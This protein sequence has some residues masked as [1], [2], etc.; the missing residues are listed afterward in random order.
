M[1]KFNVEEE[2]SCKV[3]GTDKFIAKKGAMVAFKGN[4][5]FDKMLLGPD[6]GGGVMGSLL[7]MAKRKLTGE[8]IQLMTVEGSG[9]IYLAQNAYHVSV[10][11][12][13]PGDC[14][15]VE[16]ENLLAFPLELKYDVRFIGSGVLSQKGLATTVLSNTSNQPQQVAVVTDG[17]PLML[18]AP[19][20]VDPD[21][22]VAWTSGPNG[23]GDP[24]VAMNNFS[25]KTAIGQTSGESYQFQ[26]NQSNQMVLVQPSER[27]SGLKVRVD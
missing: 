26:F 2:L 22:I 8:D 23:G 27:L 3:E 11:E 25:W 7:G 17:N 12:L 4:F 20:V 5:K 24:S 1:F 15:S 10:F 13:E 14:L 6:N 19:C 21:A 16:S 9:I 18:E